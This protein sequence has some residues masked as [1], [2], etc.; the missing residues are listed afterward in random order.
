MLSGHCYDVPPK[1]VT[2]PE[3]NRN[4][5]NCLRHHF[6]WVRNFFGD[7]ATFELILATMVS[8]SKPRSDGQTY[9]GE[10]PTIEDGTAS[11][12]G[13]SVEEELEEGGNGAVVWDNEGQPEASTSGTSG[14]ESEEYLDDEGDWEVGDEDWELAQGGELVGTQ[15]E[16][17]VVGNMVRFHKAL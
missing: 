4:S 2:G 17:A 7:T 9:I 1:A 5:W 13:S 6:N 11:S 15:Y 3:P 14:V 10:P 12:S 8:S 16:I